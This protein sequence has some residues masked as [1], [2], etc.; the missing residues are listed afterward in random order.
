M[1]QVIRNDNI[2]FY[3]ED[4]FEIM[5]IGFYMDECVWI[6]NTN[7]EI[8]VIKDISLFC[9]LDDFMNQEYIFS[10]NI[11][12]NYKDSNY[13][14]WYSDCYYDLDDEASIMNVSSLTIK[15]K[16]D[17]FY[18]LP[19]KAIDNRLNKIT[20]TYCISF[21][22]A[23]NGQYSKNL[24]TFNTLQTDFVNLIYHGLLESKSLKKQK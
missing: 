15:R 17:C 5:S 23:G 6:F 19:E 4:G 2:Y 13:L 7:K 20:K 3:D 21:S 1:K 12:Q 8:K 18:L 9:L 16:D 10:N 24:K 11:L 22:P 14:L